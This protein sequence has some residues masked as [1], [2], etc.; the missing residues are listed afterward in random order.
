[1]RSSTRSATSGAGG[2]EISTIFAVA[3]SA[4]ERVDRHQGA[5]RADP[6]VEVAAADADGV[7]DAAA[8]ARDQRGDFLEPGAGGRRRCRCRRAARR[9]RRRAA[10]RA[11]IAVPQSGPII[12]SPRSRAWRLS[13][14]SSSSGTLSEK[15]S[16]WSPRS[17]ALRASAAANS[18]GTEISARFALRQQP[19]VA[20][21]S[22]RARGS[23]SVL[24]ATL[25][26]RTA[27]C[28]RCRIASAPA[29]LVVRAGSR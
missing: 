10:C 7:R 16:T 20:P 24:A 19:A 12:R 17:S 14:A 21:P 28:R 9:W 13:A 26:F 25:A 29:A 23:D 6:R 18:P 15:I 5:E 1:M 3:G 11:M 22:P 2:L 8:R 4:V 27:A